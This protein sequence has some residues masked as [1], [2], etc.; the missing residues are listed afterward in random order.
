MTTTTDRAHRLDVEAAC[1]RMN[2]DPTTVAALVATVRT[3]HHRPDYLPGYV[4]V[5]EKAINTIH[6]RDC[7]Q[8]GCRTCAVVRIAVTA[9]TAHHLATG[10]TR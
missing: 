10:G 7:T 1:A 2:P 3:L 9:T 8:P 4:A 5:L 6:A